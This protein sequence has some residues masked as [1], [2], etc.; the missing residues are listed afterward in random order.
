MVPKFCKTVLFLFIAALNISLVSCSKDDPEFR[1]EKRD[2]NKPEDISNRHPALEKRKV[3]LFYEAGSNS[4]CYDLKKNIEVILDNYIPDRTSSSRLL[5]YSK[6]GKS[7]QSNQKSITSHLVRYY[8]DSPTGNLISDTL[9]TFSH[10]VI[11]ASAETLN[12]VLSIV[13][14]EYP[15]SEYGMVFSSHSTGWLPKDYFNNPSR[16]E[17]NK[18]RP[19]SIGQENYYNGKYYESHE[20]ELID[21]AKAIPMHL[22]YI[23]FD[24]CLM[25]SIECAY[26]LKDKCDK[27]AFSPTE[28]LA[29]GFD[30]KEMVKCLLTN[31]IPDLKGICEKYYNHYMQQHGDYQSATVSLIDCRKLDMV[32]KTFA[33]IMDNEGNLIRLAN[34]KKI[35]LIQKYF[36]LQ[37]RHWFFDLVD[38]ARKCDISKERFDRFAEA[39]DNSIIYRAATEKFLGLTINPKFYSGYSI[40]LPQEGCTYLDNKYKELAW[41]RDTHFIE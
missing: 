29:A 23:I 33:D 2:E 31:H 21:F 12:E 28:V 20:I 1:W 4:L 40:Y 19:F 34:N 8:K 10:E 39:V 26:E 41:N 7:N 27:I 9:K 18:I 37:R 36:Y 3:L 5:I 24:S 22:E 11:A 35:D 17:T 6:I 38:T 16:Y 14:E 15:N 32:A 25:G 13:K 30:Y